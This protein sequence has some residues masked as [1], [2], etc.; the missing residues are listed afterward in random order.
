MALTWSSFRSATGDHC[1][2]SLGRF[3]EAIS[4]FIDVPTRWDWSANRDEEP[5]LVTGRVSGA[6]QAAIDSLDGRVDPGLD[7]AAGG[8]MRGPGRR[9]ARALAHDQRMETPG[10]SV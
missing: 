7:V 8:R 5:G 2:G 1:L 4:R 6:A 9:M 10:R 3:S